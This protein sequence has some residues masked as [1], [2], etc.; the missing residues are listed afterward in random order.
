MSRFKGMLAVLACSVILTGTAHAQTVAPL[1]RA[2]V[3][4]FER[5]LAVLPPLLL[6]N[7]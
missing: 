4:F 1:G 7:S 3:S 5:L 6:D 2:Q